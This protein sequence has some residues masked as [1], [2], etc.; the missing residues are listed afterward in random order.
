MYKLFHFLF[1]WDYLYWQNFCDKGIARIFKNKDGIVYFYR[2]KN[3]KCIDKVE[4][5]SRSNII[6]LT[7]ERSKYID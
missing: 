6:F 1:G 4:D 3:I 2:Y 7:C 5:Y